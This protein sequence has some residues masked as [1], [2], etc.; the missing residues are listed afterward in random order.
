VLQTIEHDL[1]EE[2]RFLQLYDEFSTGLG[3]IVDMP[4]RTVSLLF[5]FFRQNNGKF[6]K[7]A[8]SKEFAELTERE[9]E[10]IEQLYADTLGAL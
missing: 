10:Q 8:L 9:V 7:R 5:R 4:H 6:S 1:P 2:A 3:A